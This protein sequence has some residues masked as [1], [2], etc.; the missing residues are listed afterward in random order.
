M[1]HEVK[2]KEQYTGLKYWSDLIGVSSQENYE[3]EEESVYELEQRLSSAISLLSEYEDFQI[4]IELLVS[5]SEIDI[6]YQDRAEF[7]TNYYT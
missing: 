4:Q 2:G 7:Q 3:I 5:D 1:T 6:Q